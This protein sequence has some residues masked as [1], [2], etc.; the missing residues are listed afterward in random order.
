MPK[1]AE[2]LALRKL[3]TEKFN[4]RPR[5]MPGQ[6]RA[7]IFGDTAHLTYVDSS[8]SLVLMLLEKRDDDWFLSSA[9]SP[10]CNH[11]GQMDLVYWPRSFSLD[12]NMTRAVQEAE[13]QKEGR[14]HP[15]EEDDDDPEGEE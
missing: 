6:Y 8:G 5:F 1:S 7:K 11:E 12:D 3:D 15:N 4:G 2:I 14:R 13:A 9:Q 10:R